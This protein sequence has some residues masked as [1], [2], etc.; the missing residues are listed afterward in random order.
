MIC[1]AG[2]SPGQVI[3]LSTWHQCGCLMLVCSPSSLQARQRLLPEGC[4]FP[5]RAA[6][7]VPPCGLESRR[8]GAADGGVNRHKAI[9]K[10]KHL[11]LREEAERQRDRDRETQ[12]HKNIETEGTHM[13]TPRKRDRRG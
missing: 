1:E 2:T 7:L 6:E 12:R 13:H 5:V 10:V 8:V 3:L 11:L 4:R 9:H